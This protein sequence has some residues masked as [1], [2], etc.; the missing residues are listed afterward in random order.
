MST[1]LRVF[2]F[3]LLLGLPFVLGFCVFDTFFGT[4]VPPA[5]GLLALLIEV[6]V[7]HTLLWFSALFG[8]LLALLIS[9]SYRDKTLTKF[10][11][12][13]ERDERELQ[14]TGQAV[15]MAFLST[16][17]LLLVL[18][19][20]SVFSVVVYELPLA[21]QSTGGTHELSMSLN[22]SLLE[23]A[24]AKTQPQFSNAVGL[25]Q[26]PLSNLGLLLL[27]LAWHVLSF[28]FF[29]RRQI[30]PEAG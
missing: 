30:N 24:S 3:Y 14:V 15:R 19:F 6:G 23:G 28:R 12:M 17:A 25:T 5:P 8:F 1:F 20:T 2:H 7:W 13:R 18:M 21:E 9:G 16:L 22:L 10:T 11:A 29:L 27:V 4:Q 26:L